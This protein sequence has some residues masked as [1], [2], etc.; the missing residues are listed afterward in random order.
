MKHMEGGMGPVKG[1]A[2]VVLMALAAGCHGKNPG[3]PS[4]SPAQS[5][6][7]ATGLFINGVDAV[8]TGSVTSYAVTATLSDGTTRTVTP[9]WTSS[10]PG[11]GSVDGSGRL[12]GRAHGSTT[13]TASYLGRDVSKTVNVVN[14]YGGTWTGQYIIRACDDSG[15]L[16]DHDGGWCQ[17]RVPVGTVWSI[18]L[19]LSQ[20]AS[21]LSEIGGTLGLADVDVQDK[22]TGVVTADGRLSL[23]GTL[24]LLDFYGESLLGTV[25][26]QTWE[27]NVSGPA[28]MTGRW[29]Q[30]FSSIYFRRGNAL[31]QNELVTMTRSSDGA[32]AVS[33]R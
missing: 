1:I 11:V 7:I 4:E 10:N 31:T 16:K 18:R 2:A 15:D 22:I 29:A 32:L 33:P 25:Q 12:D 21:D 20:T 30:N 17:S 9:A 13:L 26:L 19:V 23:T 6:A 3:A 8:L 27:T 24:H 14:N 28:V 5:A